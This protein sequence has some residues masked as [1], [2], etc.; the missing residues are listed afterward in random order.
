MEEIINKSIEYISNLY[1]KADNTKLLF[2]N[3]DHALEV[4]NNIVEIGENSGLT[5]KEIFLL[6]LAAIFH[7]TG[8]IEN[9]EDHESRSALIAENFLAN[10]GIPDSDIK[11]IS[12]LIKI[13]DI[14]LT[15]KTL[16]EKVIRDADILHVGRKGFNKKS[17]LLRAEKELNL[18]KYF[19]DKQWLEKNIDFSEANHFF[20]DYAKQQYQSKKKKIF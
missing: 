16:L 10:N 6:R 5:A 15:P 1:S 13:T 19:N 18:N 14:S 2:H 12:D 7:D 11:T 4:Q 9:K 17:Q 8:W 20:T 3:L